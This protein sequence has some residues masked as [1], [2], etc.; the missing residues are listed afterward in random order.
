MSVTQNAQAV[1]QKW[2]TNTSAAVPA[3]KAGVM[4]V[5]V[6]PG[7]AA[8]AAVQQWLQ[9]VQNAA[10]KF[11][12]NSAAVTLQ[13]WQTAAS[14]LGAAR[15]PSGVQNAQPRMQNFMSQL[16]PHAA[17]VSAQ[18]AAM[19][20]GGLAN[21]IARATAAITAMANFKYQKA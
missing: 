14:N 21:G 15:L 16:L 19:P 11:A 13:S 9:G 6:A 7:Q 2:A 3:Y 4:A 1:A 5:T 20:K 8:A 18:V 12:T 10:Q 17:N